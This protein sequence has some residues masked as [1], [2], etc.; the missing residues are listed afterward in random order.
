[1]VRLEAQKLGRRPGRREVSAGERV[2]EGPAATDRLWV[3]AEEERLR[4]QYRSVIAVGCLTDV[5][6]RRHDAVRRRLVARRV[7]HGGGWQE[8]EAGHNR[9]DEEKRTHAHRLS[10]FLRSHVAGSSPPLEVS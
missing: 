5:R 9:N 2:R 10:P 8:A 4:D 6:S 1:A 3:N 7:R